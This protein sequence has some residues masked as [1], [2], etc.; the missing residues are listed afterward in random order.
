MVIETTKT[1]CNLYFE[2]KLEVFAFRK[3]KEKEKIVAQIYLFMIFF[4]KFVVPWADN[5]GNN[6]EQTWLQQH[7][8]TLH[9]FSCDF[10]LPE[11]SDFGQKAGYLCPQGDVQGGGEGRPERRGGWL[12]SGG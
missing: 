5:W 2:I 4:S 8:L 6:L 11:V 10:P 9:S 12:Q 1:K 3:K 7:M